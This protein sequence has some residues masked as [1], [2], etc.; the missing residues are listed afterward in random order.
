MKVGG[1]DGGGL[2][3]HVDVLVADL[4]ELQGHHRVRRIVERLCVE[5]FAAR[6]GRERERERERLVS[7]GAPEPMPDGGSTRV[8]VWRRT[9]SGGRRS[10]SPTC[11][12]TE[13]GETTQ[14]RRV[15][16]RSEAEAQRESG[17]ALLLAE[18]EV[19]QRRW[20]PRLACTGRQRQSCPCSACERM[21]QC[22]RTTGTGRRGTW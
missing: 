16:V 18:A 22:T 3:A 10:T 15:E 20:Q 13:A 17:S 14:Q 4:A 7:G 6:R 5:V 8:C 9:Y 1:A 21:P 2:D 11:V 19:L 12:N